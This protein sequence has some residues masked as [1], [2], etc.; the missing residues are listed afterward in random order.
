MDEYKEY[1]YNRRPHY[2]SLDYGDVSK[3]KALRQKLKCKPFKWFMQEVA[4]DQPLKYP[5]VEPPDFAWG[6]VRN[7]A[8]GKCLDSKFLDQGKRFGLDHCMGSILGGRSGEQNFVL[9]WHRDLRPA[10]RNVCLD[11][12]SGEKR[13]PVVLWTCHGM[14][15]NQLFKYNLVSM[16]DASAS[17]A[18]RDLTCTRSLRR[19][20]FVPAGQPFCTY[21]LLPDF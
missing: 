16:S 21:F 12:S 19:R 6:T 13:A 17:R 4:F 10:K 8:S 5:P 2:R 1:L 14:Q 15:G 9:T 20:R 18:L 3:Q 7:I 11:V